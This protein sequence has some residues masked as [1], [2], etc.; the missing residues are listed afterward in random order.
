MWV[1]SELQTTKWMEFYKSIFDKFCW[2]GLALIQPNGSII[3]AKNQITTATGEA[4]I[5]N[6][7]CAFWMC[8]CNHGNVR[9]ISTIKIPQSYDTDAI[10][11]CQN[12]SIITG[13]K[14]CKII[15]AILHGKFSNN[16]EG[17]RTFG[18]C[19]IIRWKWRCP[20]E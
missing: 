12:R 1:V 17:L 16:G 20:A 19:S 9:G 3:T 15:I 4:K 14:T 8:Q 7:F 6:V 13:C 2:G 18:H 5:S 10:A 11:Q